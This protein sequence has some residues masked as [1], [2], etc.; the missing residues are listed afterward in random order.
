MKAIVNDVDATLMQFPGGLTFVFVGDE[1]AGTAEKGELGVWTSN[2]HL[3]VPD[4]TEETHDN[5]FSAVGA[6]VT[7]HAVASLMHVLA[8]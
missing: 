1:Y 5:M 2:P 6:V 7:T 4:L 3:V 8:V